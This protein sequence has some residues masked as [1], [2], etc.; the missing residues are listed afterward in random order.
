[1]GMAGLDMVQNMPIEQIRSIMEVLQSSLDA[2]LFIL[3]MTSEVYYIPEKLTERVALDSTRVENCMEALKAIVYPSDYAML[4]EDIAR[5]ASGEQDK[6]DLEYRWLGRDNR[7]IWIN[8]QGAVITD[9][10]GHRLLV[11]R[12]SELGRQ[13][14]ADNVTGLRRETRFRLDVEEILRDRPESIRYCM[15]VG[16]D[17]FKEINEKDGTEAGDLILYE[18]SKCITD[19]V[20]E[21]VSVYR[22]VADEFMLIDTGS[23]MVEQPAE[24]YN[25]IKTKIEKVIKGKDYSGFYTIS[26]GILNRD[27]AGKSSEDIM[28]LSEFALNEAKRKGKNQLAFF[29]QKDYDQYLKHLDIRKEIRRDISNQFAGFEVYYQPIVE[30]G[31]YRIIGAEALLRWQSKKYGSVSPAVMI[32]IMEES[33]LII[34]IG[35]YVLWEAAKMCKKWKKIIPE[36]HVNVNLSYVQ[37]H[38]SDLMNDVSACMQEVG[39]S[40]DS[41]VLELTESGS[42]ETDNRIQKLLQDLK[43]SRINLAIDDFGTGY[44]NMRY[45]KEIQAKTVKLDRSFVLQALKND[46]DYMIITHLIDMIHS[47][48]STVCMEGIEYDHELEKMKSTKPD[49]IQ[50]YLFGRPSPAEVFE[51]FLLEN[52]KNGQ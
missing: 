29:E 42:I 4:A 20:V 2:Y 3:D 11:G 27:F 38:K 26:A 24:I 22:L 5:C 35:R 14:K 6:H 17:N 23:G 34:P 28:K 12:V 32:P 1:M 30:A 10:D 19:T 9:A 46:Y 51:T 44:S 50:G 33:G 15:R 41:L 16:I 36:F 45:L 37:V 25:Q 52:G 47:L 18:L 13:A 31:S 39:I 7:V 49:M 21:E 8:C 43:D 48:G 40:P